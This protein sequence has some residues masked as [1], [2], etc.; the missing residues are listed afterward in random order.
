MGKV[1]E[2]VGKVPRREVMV[3]E[4]YLTPSTGKVLT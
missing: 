1:T 3:R 2:E 4:S